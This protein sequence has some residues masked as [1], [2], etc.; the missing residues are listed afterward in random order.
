MENLPKNDIFKTPVDYFDSL[1]EKILEKR[2]RKKTR[3]VYFQS[4]AAAAMVVIG[5]IVFLLPYEPNQ[6]SSLEANLDAEVNLYINAGHWNAEDILSLSDNPNSILDEIIESE[7][8]G[9]EDGVE[10]QYP[11]EIWF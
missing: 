2:K 11:E 10:N 4:I 6:E 8:E 9:F 5:L 1:P 7:W 3:I